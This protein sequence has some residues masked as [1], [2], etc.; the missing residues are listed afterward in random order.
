MSFKYS[1]KKSVGRFKWIAMA[2][3]AIVVTTVGAF[4][5]RSRFAPATPPVTTGTVS[6]N[7]NPPGALVEVDGAA[8]GQTPIS[9]SVTAGAHTLVVRGSGEPRTIPITVTAGAQLSQYIELPLA[10]TIIG[11]LAV[12]TSRPARR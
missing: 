7:T 2:A 8:R 12:H 3:A 11:Q 1:S 6:V 9:L 5:A 10:N 4:A